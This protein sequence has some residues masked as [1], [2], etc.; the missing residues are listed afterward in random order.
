MF[1]THLSDNTTEYNGT[2]YELD[3]AFNNVLSVFDILG[4]DILTTVEKLDTALYMLTNKE[5][6]EMGLN[7]IEKSELLNNIFEQHIGDAHKEK[8]VEY[9]LKGKPM[10]VR[11]D[12]EMDEIPYS[13]V[14]DA[15][16]IY[17]SFVQAYNIDLF[18][19]HE[20]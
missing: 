9:D 8:Y 18:E 17:A 19:E 6:D 12:N 14:H 10:P 7:P 2:T 16:Y 1:L 4:D 3:L 15:E 5:V 11:E 13:F 20:N